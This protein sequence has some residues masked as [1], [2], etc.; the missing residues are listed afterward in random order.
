MFRVQFRITGN[1]GIGGGAIDEGVLEAAG[2]AVGILEFKAAVE[3][4]TGVMAAG[5]SV[6]TGVSGMGVGS[7]I[8]TEYLIGSLAMSDCKFTSCVC[9]AITP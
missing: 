9:G 5:I 6:A 4:A 7:Q 1:C 3:A 2:P 8:K